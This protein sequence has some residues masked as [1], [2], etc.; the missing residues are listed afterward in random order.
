MSVLVTGSV[1][2]D[3]IMVFPDRFDRHILKDQLHILNVVF[4]VPSL[5]KRFGGTAANIAYNLRRLGEDP[6]VL[7]TVGSDFGDYARWMDT[8]GIRRDLIRVLSDAFT[9]QCF[10]TTDSA[11]NQIIVFHPGAM[12]RGHEAKVAEVAE[13]FR[14]G[15][16]APNGKQAMQEHAR[17]LKARG[18]ICVVDPGQ[19]LPLFDA[20]ELR[21]MIEGASIYIVNDYEWETTKERLGWSED[22]VA[23]R[24]GALIVTRGERG[25]FLRRG[26]LDLDFGLD[27]ERLELPAVKAEA[28]V[29]PTGCGDAYRSGLLYA[30]EHGLP[31]ADG[32]RLGAVMGALKI[33]RSGPQSIVEDRDAVRACFEREF[34]FALP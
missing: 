19:G 8:C 16:V 23:E 17:A 1:A 27:E 20:D 28:V 25:S 6:L 24:V 5:E 15:I 2:I 18:S 34:G 30:L 7:A 22:E 10:I 31:L 3:H 29:D 11:E 26:G 32:A 14:V 33:A 21:E 12:D 9:A 13:A 4:A